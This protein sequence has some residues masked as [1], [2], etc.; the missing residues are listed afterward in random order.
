MHAKRFLLLILAITSII[1]PLGLYASGYVYSDEVI[2]QTTST[3]QKKVENSF[4]TFNTDLRLIKLCAVVFHSRFDSTLNST[5]EDFSLWLIS[6]SSVSSPTIC[7][8]TFE[9][10]Y[11]Y[12]NELL[13]L[14]IWPAL[15]AAIGMLVDNKHKK[16]NGSI[17]EMV[18]RAIELNPGIHFRKL[19]RELNRK[20]GVIQYH[21]QVLE[22]KENRIRSHQDGEKFTRYFPSN[23]HLA[24]LANGNYYNL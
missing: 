17:R 12:L 3:A 1:A 24:K 5:R 7:P 19:C 23:S 4:N 21:L 2:T 6:R 18:Y 8:D 15:L 13:W 10:Y 14:V 20:T 16:E 22:L 9:I 11:Q